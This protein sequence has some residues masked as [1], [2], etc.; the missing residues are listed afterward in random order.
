MA[1]FSAIFGSSAVW[2]LLFA[3]LALAAPLRASAAVPAWVTDDPLSIAV[4]CHA[5]PASSDA[6]GGGADTPA[7]P[8]G[9]HC[10]WCLGF[11]DAAMFLP[12]AARVPLPG[13]AGI[14]RQ[15]TGVE[16][17]PPD[18]TFRRTAQPRAPPATIATA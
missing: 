1:R 9:T 5:E 14:L 10:P 12:G 4:I 11:A 6:A 3:L 16:S 17:A 7:A 18:L 8:S 13:F 2:R 15:T